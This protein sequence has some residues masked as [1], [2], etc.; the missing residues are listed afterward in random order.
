M[1]E[2]KKYQKAMNFKANPRYLRRDFIVPLY[3]GTEPDIVPETSVEELGAVQEFN[4][5]GRVGFQKA[6]RVFGELPQDVKQYKGDRLNIF[7]EGLNDLIKWKKNPTADNWIKIFGYTSASGQNRTSE[8]SKNLRSYL[9]GEKQKESTKELFDRIKIK[10]YLKNN[11]KDIKNLDASLIEKRQTAGSKARAEQQLAASAERIKLINEQF[12][13][14]PTIGLDDLTK[15]IYKTKFTKADDL[16]K[17]KLSTQV[18]DDVAKYLEALKGART[19]IPGLPTGNKLKN[20]SDH[21]EK[22]TVLFRFREGNLR[23]YKFNIADKARGFDIN[24]TE[25]LINK[26]RGK[27]RVADE[28]VGLSATFKN[29]PGYLEATQ[30][31]KASTNNL[32]GRKIDKFFIEAFDL[33]LKGDKSKVKDYNKRALQFK[34]KNPN[35]DV[36]FI[37]YGNTLNE[38]KNNIKHFDDFS[39]ASKENILKIAK[40]NNIIIKTQAKPLTKIVDEFKDAVNTTDKI[41][42]SAKLKNLGLNPKQGALYT[43]FIPGLESFGEDLAT[44]KYGKATLKGLGVLGT[45]IGAK[46]FVE[47]YDAGEPILDTVL[48]GGFGIPGPV[49][50]LAK[51]KNF[52]PEGRLAEK[53]LDTLRDFR[54]GIF[55]PQD[56]AIVAKKLDPQYQGDPNQYLNFLEQ[57]ESIFKKDIELAEEK[58]QKETMQPFK[59]EKMKTRLPIMETPV[60]KKIVE[61]YRQIVPEDTETEIEIEQPLEQPPEELPSEYKVSAADGGRIGLS[62]GSGPKIGRRGFLGLLTGVA[63]APELIKSIKGTKKAAKTVGTVSKIKF[64]KT[65]GMYP[66][67][68]D[69]VEKIKIKGKPFEEKE[70]IMEASYKHEPKGYGGLPKGIEK[71]TRHVDGD[72]EFL[73]REYPDGRIA[74][75]IHSPRNQEGS[76]TPVTLYYRPTMKLKYYNK[77]MVEPAEFKVLEKEPRYFANGPDDVD[78]EM[79]ETRKIPGKD[80]IFGDV[81]AAERFATGKIQNRKIIPAKQSRREQME[82]APSDFIEETSP[83]GPDTF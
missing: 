27:G 12:K 43:S 26:I 48:Y 17:L 69:L 45:A 29:A 60:I 76:S 15:N 37:K 3:T 51:Y 47:M 40:E 62:K 24:Y 5:G 31:L 44:G 52:P 8:F 70:I 74:V 63:A 61:N 34:N 77:E 13:K 54:E 67:F 4:D 30:F 22:N 49:T 55:K 1:S 66:W 28:A 25:N 53:R 23:R 36:P 35:V 73:L 42:Q 41:Q 81:E 64:E 68:P 80:T 58:F 38:V 78:I 32:K 2:I 18:S 16:E 21:I 46:D 72:T 14:N 7:E 39:D 10:D 65:E 59:E 6:G 75:D 82:D 83:Y 79:S 20:I 57:N 71:V 33:A 50:A 19:G 9:K 56:V 11:I